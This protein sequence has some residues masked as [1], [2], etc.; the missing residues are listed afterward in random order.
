M[1]LAEDYKYFDDRMLK[2]KFKLSD[3][4]NLSRL[5]TFLS[6]VHHQFYLLQL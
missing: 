3:W 2:Y 6:Y 1:K 4:N 5:R